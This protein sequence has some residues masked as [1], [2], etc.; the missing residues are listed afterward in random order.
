MWLLSTIVVSQSV[1]PVV[2][3][4]FSSRRRHTRCSRDWSSDVCSSDLKEAGDRLVVQFEPFRRLLGAVGEAR[5][6][7]AVD[8]DPQAVDDPLLQPA[9]IPSNPSSV[10]A[11]SMTAVVTTVMPRSRAYSL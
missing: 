9:H 6:Q 1:V 8:H 4:F 11:A 3:F 10:R 2:F 5:A 7:L